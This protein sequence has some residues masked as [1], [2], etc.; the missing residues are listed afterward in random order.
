MA[1]AELRTPI[2]VMHIDEDVAGIE[3]NDEVLCKVSDGIDAQLP[4]GEQDR[5]RLGDAESGTHDR[6][7][8]HPPHPAARPTAARSR[9][10]AISGTVEHTNFAFATFAN[11]G[12]IDDR[13]EA[14]VD[15][16]RRTLEAQARRVLRLESP[17]QL[18]QDTALAAGL[19]DIS[20]RQGKSDDHYRFV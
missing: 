20:L 16:V 5:A 11:T 7:N 17:A 19:G 15:E 6:E 8:Q 4:V 2:S 3:E 13:V 1:A 14:A 9:L 18:A 10:P 12:A